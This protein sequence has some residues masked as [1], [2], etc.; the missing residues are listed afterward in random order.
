MT[1]EID[2]GETL[3]KYSDQ[4]NVDRLVIEKQ[5]LHN[6]RQGWTPLS[7]TWEGLKEIVLLGGGPSLNTHRHELDE[8]LKREVP[9]VTVNGSYHWA[10]KNHIWPSMQIVVDARELNA[11]F[12]H[13]VLPGTHYLIADSCHSSV[14]RGLPKRKTYLWDRH[15]FNGGSTVMLCAMALLRWMGMQHCSIFGLDSC[16]G[17]DRQHHAYP[18]PENDGETLLEIELEERKF[19]CTSWMIEQAEEFLELSPHWGKFKVHGDGMIAW[20]LNKHD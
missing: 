19:L 9:V 4:Q 2:T 3:T 11:R 14:L 8:L 15:Q 17:H 10:R 5:R 13:P 16:L 18:Q 7:K 6:R 12:T 1:D 20:M